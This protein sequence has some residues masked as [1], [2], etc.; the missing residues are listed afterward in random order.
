MRVEVKRAAARTTAEILVYGSTVLD[1][2]SY[3]ESLIRSQ[4]YL[5]A[6]DSFDELLVLTSPEVEALSILA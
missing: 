1:V 3:Q 4:E 5:A 6:F 2:T